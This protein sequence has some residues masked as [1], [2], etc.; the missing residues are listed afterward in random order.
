ML[1]FLLSYARPLRF[2]KA[3]FKYRF[4]LFSVDCVLSIWTSWSECSVSCGGGSQARYRS[5][6]TQP[7]CNGKQCDQELVQHQQCNENCIHGLMRDGSCSCEEGW[8][9]TCCNYGNI[10]THNYGVL[11]PSESAQESEFS[12]EIDSGRPPTLQD[13]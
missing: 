3:I 10:P 11:I 12:F 5:I 8:N 9:G 7:E 4:F 13:T 2:P 6:L 1:I